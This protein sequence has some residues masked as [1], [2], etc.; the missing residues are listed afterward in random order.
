MMKLYKARQEEIL[1]KNREGR[2]DGT[3]ISTEHFVD[4]RIKKMK[5]RG[6]IDEL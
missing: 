1:K 4:T 3:A 5:G 6:V 2:N